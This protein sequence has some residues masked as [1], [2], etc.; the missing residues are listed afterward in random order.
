MAAVVTTLVSRRLVFIIRFVNKK[1]LVSLVKGQANRLLE[2]KLSPEMEI[3]YVLS[4]GQKVR[5]PSTIAGQTASE[6]SV[7]VPRILNRHHC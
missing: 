1:A 3:I 4:A 2:S 5:S 6:R 7:S